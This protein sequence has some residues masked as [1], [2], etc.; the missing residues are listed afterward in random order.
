MNAPLSCKK[1]MVARQIRPLA[2]VHW[3]QN[4]YS[5]HEQGSD[6]CGRS[7]IDELKNEVEMPVNFSPQRQGASHSIE[8]TDVVL[9]RGTSVYDA[10]LGTFDTR[11]CVR[12]NGSADRAMWLYHPKHAD[13]LGM[14]SEFHLWTYH[15]SAQAIDSICCRLTAVYQQFFAFQ[16]EPDANDA[17]DSITFWANSPRATV[18]LPRAHDARR[19]YPQQQVQA[20]VT[21]CNE[22]YSL[23]PQPAIVALDRSR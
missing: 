21:A 2:V 22:I 12:K 5:K 4:R 18:I 17:V 11:I 1:Q 3:S 7:S 8:P 10:N 15:L 13:G 19:R 20:F 9:L 23:L 16:A 14:T 6:A